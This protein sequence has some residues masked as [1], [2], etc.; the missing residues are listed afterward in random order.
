MKVIDDCVNAFQ[1]SI[2][3]FQV[4][5]SRIPWPIGKILNNRNQSF[6]DVTWSSRCRGFIRTP[7]AAGGY[8]WNYR[9]NVA[10]GRPHRGPG[11]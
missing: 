3:R 10:E 11:A 1:D 8:L 4:N 6:S 2:A 9:G 5:L 7:G